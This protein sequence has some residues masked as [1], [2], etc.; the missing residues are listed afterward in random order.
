MHPPLAA[1][2]HEKKCQLIIQQLSDCHVEHPVAK[3][4]GKCNDIKLALNACLQ[5][6]YE[7]RRRLNHEEAKK[8]REKW[9]NSSDS[10]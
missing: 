3:F 6:E 10:L 7:S 8:R 9:L 5:E 2:L 4:L 1:H